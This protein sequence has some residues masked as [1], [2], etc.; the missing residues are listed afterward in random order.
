MRKKFFLFRRSNPLGPVKRF[1]ENGKDI[2]IL[3]IAA[4]QIGFI[5][6]GRG[7]INITFNG[8]SIYED[9]ELFAGDSIEKT[10]IS[11]SCQ[12]GSEMELIE[13]IMFFVSREDSKTIMKFDVLDNVSPFREVITTSVSD[14]SS[15]IKAQ[16]T[17]RVSQKIS[18]G[19][20]AKRFANIIGEINF[21]T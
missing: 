13:K 20:V 12:E 9:N 17:E 8:A 14:I 15:K 1:S 19:E 16:P 5:T 7:E 2:S 3:G 4:D 6:A 11:I 18:P 21:G 10:N